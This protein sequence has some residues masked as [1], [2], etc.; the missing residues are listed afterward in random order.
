MPLLLPLVVKK[1]V[2]GHVD[3]RRYCAH[4]TFYMPQ[5]ERIARDAVDGFLQPM[6]G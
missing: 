5:Y 2:E 6:M 1:V 4:D 3:D